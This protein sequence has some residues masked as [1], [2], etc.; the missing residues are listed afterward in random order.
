MVVSFAMFG[1]IKG[2]VALAVILFATIS[3]W[4]MG[5]WMR[6]RARRALGRDISSRELNSIHLWMDVQDAEHRE[7]PRTEP[8]LR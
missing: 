2:I 6:R 3:A 4:I 1:E 7:N 8:P 5:V